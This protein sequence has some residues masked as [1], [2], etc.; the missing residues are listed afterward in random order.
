MNTCS[1]TTRA[2]YNFHPIF[3][4]KHPFDTPSALFQVQKNTL[5]DVL[6]KS[7]AAGAQLSV[8]RAAN[9]FEAVTKYMQTGVPQWK[10]GLTVNGTGSA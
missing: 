4:E 8:D 3:M 7:T 6:I 2:K 10:T 9:G 5:S 1:F